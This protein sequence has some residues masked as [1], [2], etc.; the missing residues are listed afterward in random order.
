[1]PVDSLAATLQ[2][3]CVA[4]HFP[5][6]PA[7]CTHLG[8]WHGRYGYTPLRAI[9]QSAH[10]RQVLT[11]RPPFFEMTEVAATYSMVNGARPSRPNHHEISDRIWRT[12]ERCWHTVP[13]RRMSI[14]EVVGL[15][16][17]EL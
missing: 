9:V 14:E 3:S 6:R 8:L 17:A 2:K 4:L 12:V 11:G 13:S 10:S 15:L 16:E 7:T 1:V 5:P